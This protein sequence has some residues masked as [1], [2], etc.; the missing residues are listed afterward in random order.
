M[1]AVDNLRAG[2]LLCYGKAPLHRLGSQPQ[3]VS[4]GHAPLGA[5]LIHPR[6]QGPTVAGLAWQWQHGNRH[7]CEIGEQTMAQ[8]GGFGRVVLWVVL[9]IVGIIVAGTV[10]GWLLSALWKILVATLIIGAIVGVSAL[11]IG[12]VRRSI[13]GGNNPPRLPR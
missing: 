4:V 13:S 12:V 9:G 6:D 2:H 1:P 5:T 8:G 10:I 3:P 7:R 11:V